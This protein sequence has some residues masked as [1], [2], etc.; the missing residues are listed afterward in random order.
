[1]ENELADRNWNI[2]FLGAASVIISALGFFTYMASSIPVRNPLLVAAGAGIVFALASK[3]EDLEKLKTLMRPLSGFLNMTAG[4]MLIGSAL[5]FGTNS[6]PIAMEALNQF[7]GD[8]LIAMIRIVLLPLLGYLTVLF[9][10]FIAGTG[11]SLVL[12]DRVDERVPLGAGKTDFMFTGILAALT[13]FGVFGAAFLKN[14]PLG[15]FIQSFTQL[16]L[17]STDFATVIASIL[18]L[19]SYRTV[20]VAWKALP[21]RESVPRSSR[22]T[23]DKLKKP[24]KAVRWLV[25]PA[26]SLGIAVQGF[27]DLKYLNYFAPLSSSTA[28]KLFAVVILISIAA[29]IGVKVLKILTSGRDKLK[30]L[31]PY[32]LFGVVAYLAAPFLTGY[33]SVLNGLPVVS[34]LI[35]AV[36][37]TQFV[38]ILMTVASAATVM[39]KIFMGVLRGFGLVP[40]G[41]EGTTMAASGIFFS[42]I[43]YHLYN[44]DVVLLFTGVAVSM[45]A[46]ELGKRSVILG[47]EIGRSG[48]TYQAELV[49]VLS[50]IVIA[51]VAVVAARTVL[52]AVKNMTFS[53]PSGTSGFL[54][55]LLTLL[56]VGLL[57]A[58]LKDFT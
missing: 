18:F 39:L 35:D 9:G 29:Y 30:R 58:S 53:V 12:W 4:A 20:R 32:V 26:L 31:I 19:V 5:L 2:T 6:I 7:N 25:I 17:H 28:R 38:M 44:P 41:L 37:P 34:S 51:F 45:A 11:S 54:I 14:L 48:S 50:K 42:S 33:I 43:G 8:S 15:K 10:V 36:G 49:Q 22:E 40:K 1:M 16:V 52:V 56:G 55:F 21:I 3:V 27:I 57:T 24:E 47:R 46:W 13:L 23:Y